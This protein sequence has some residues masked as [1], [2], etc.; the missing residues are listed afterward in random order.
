MRDLDLE[1]LEEH[2][3]PRTITIPDGIN[4]KLDF[5]KR[6]EEDKKPVILSR[7]QGLSELEKMFTDSNTKIYGWK[8][9]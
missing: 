1:S 3:P 4:I 8:K 6:Y 5:F 7:N 2:K 9:D